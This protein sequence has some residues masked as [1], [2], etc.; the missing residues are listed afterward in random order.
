MK[1]QLILLSFAALLSTTT[2]MEAAGVAL[3]AHMGRFKEEMNVGD[4]QKVNAE[5]M[6]ITAGHDVVMLT[7]KESGKW[8][9]TALKAGTATVC[10]EKSKPGYKSKRHKCCHTIVV[11]G[12]NGIVAKAK[13]VAK[14]VAADVEDVAQDI[15]QDV[16]MLRQKAKGMRQGVKSGVDTYKQK[17]MERKATKPAQKAQ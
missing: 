2:F 3:F 17:K 8:V 15:E 14:R 11:T 4:E 12:K 7:E 5:T 10:L 1:K 16:S 13:R 6:H 9:V